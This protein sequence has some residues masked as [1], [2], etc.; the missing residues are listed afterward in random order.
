MAE[1]DE[2]L[3]ACLSDLPSCLFVCFIPGGFCCL[4][5]KAVD[6]ATGEGLLVPYIFPCLTFCIGAAFNRGKI[7]N[8]YRIEGN[9]VTDCLIEWLCSLCAV[10]QEYREVNRREGKS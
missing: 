6:K 10:T 4:Q 2:G 9:F 1:F 5:A 7:R 3:C 8:K